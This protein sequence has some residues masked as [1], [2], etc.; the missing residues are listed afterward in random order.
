M[1][2]NF[3]M[4]LT[5]EIRKHKN[6]YD[7]SVREYKDF[8]RSRNSWNE[9][10][11]TLGKDAALCKAK[12]K[13]LRD[14]FVKARKKMRGKSGDGANGGVP[15][16]FHMLSWLDTFIKSRETETNVPA[17][18][19]GSSSGVPSPACSSNNSNQWAPSPSGSSS[20]NTNPCD[21]P[22]L[23]ALS[24]SH[25]AC[26]SEFPAPRESSPPGTSTPTRTKL[27]RKRQWREI[28]LMKRL[29]AIDQRRVKRALRDDEDT[30]FASAMA[31]LLKKL[32]SGVKSQ[33]RFR[34]HELLFNIEQEYAHLQTHTLEPP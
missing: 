12:W 13:Y 17:D 1:K 11:Q 23:S 9:I 31:D 26:S 29:E 14:R 32:P 27:G 15:P 33:A 4:R 2:P 3:E 34:V 6:L 24:S 18:F 21:S 28:A 25:P 7:T 30:R 5:E 10:A 20:N 19:N 22:A 8:Q 16:I